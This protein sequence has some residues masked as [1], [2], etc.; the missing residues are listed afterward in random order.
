MRIKMHPA[1][2]WEYQ[3]VLVTT[4]LSCAH[5][6]APLWSCSYRCGQ[7]VAMVSTTHSQPSFC[8]L[9]H[10]AWPFLLIWD[11]S[12]LAPICSAPTLHPGHTDPP[13]GLSLNVFLAYAKLYVQ[14]CWHSVGYLWQP[15]HPT[16]SVPL[17]IPHARE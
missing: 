3:E 13:S 17:A 1:I 6:S 14:A 11:R 10:W 7:D 16:V 4:I 12:I 15:Q 9:V 2:I 8:S 5:G